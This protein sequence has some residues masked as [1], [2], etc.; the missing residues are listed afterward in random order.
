MSDAPSPHRLDRRAALKF[1]ATG[2][3]GAAVPVSRADAQDKPTTPATP[4]PFDP[5]VAAPRGTLTDPNLTQPD[6]CP[7]TKLLT[8]AELE[9][10][11]VLADIILP[12][13]EKS[14]AASK[15]G[16]PEFINEWIS[17]PYEVQ[18][19]DRAIVRGGLA[20]L[21]TESF[22]QDG[23]R[24]TELESAKQLAICDSIASV[25]KAAPELKIPAQFFRKF[26]DLCL[27][28]FY[29]TSTGFQDLGYVGNTPMPEFPGP[30]QEILKKLGLV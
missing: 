7:W 22:K 9:T 30:P 27:S 3:A 6:K 15:A 14:P 25:A 1:L 16:V 11:T 18:E 8:P 5:A 24:F 28:G 21:N 12:E 26:A 4:P 23:K 19:A 10:V 13:D 20:W 2:A 17:A 29:T